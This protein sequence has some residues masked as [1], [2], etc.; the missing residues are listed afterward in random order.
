MYGG[1]GFVHK[2]FNFL[3]RVT[4]KDYDN[5]DKVWDINGDDFGNIE[6]LR[7]LKLANLSFN[8]SK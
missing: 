6:D 1:L 2:N 8:D 3:S 5:K 4:Y 7:V